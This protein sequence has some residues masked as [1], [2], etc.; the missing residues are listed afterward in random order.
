MDFVFS[1]IAPIENNE[2]ITIYIMQ[3]D[4]FKMIPQLKYKTFHNGKE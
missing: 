2:K 4:T 3:S 1:S